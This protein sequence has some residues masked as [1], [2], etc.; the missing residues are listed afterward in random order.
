MFAN[1]GIEMGKKA[2][3]EMRVPRTCGRQT[4]RN[5]VAGKTPAAYFRRTAFLPFL[6]NPLLCS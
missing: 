3:V 5:N 4:L 6:D 2:G 1:K